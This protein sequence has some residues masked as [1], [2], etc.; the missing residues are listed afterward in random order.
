MRKGEVFK[1]TLSNLAAD[2]LL[3]ASRTSH[4]DKALAT[5]IDACDL[6]VS[7]YE[8]LGK[9][10]RPGL[11]AVIDRWRERAPKAIQGIETFEDYRNDLEQRVKKANSLSAEKR[12]ASLPKSGHKPAFY[13]VSTTVYH[14]SAAVVAETLE[15][16]KGRCENCGRDA[17]FIRAKDGT[18]YLEIHHKTPLAEHGDD[19]LAN[20]IALCPN[21]HR[22]THFG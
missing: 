16:A 4:G 20:A 19:T 15:R 6:H 2:T 18:P 11:R 14:R 22:M 1:R 17:P 12:K 5:A 13:S 9:S 21:C 3:S 8:G 7:Y 10:K